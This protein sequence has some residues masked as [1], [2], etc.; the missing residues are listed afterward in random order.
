MHHS[1]NGGKLYQSLKAYQLESKKSIFE[2][3][4][5]EKEHHQLLTPSS[6]AKFWRTEAE[7]LRNQLDD[8]QENYRRLKGDELSGMRISD[9]HNLENELETRLKNIRIKKEKMLTDEIEELNRK[10]SLIGHE[11]IEL[12]KKVTLIHQENRELHKKVHG[13][14]D[15]RKE[16]GSCSGQTSGKES[17]V[18]LHLRQ[19][20]QQLNVSR[21]IPEC[22]IS[23]GLQLQ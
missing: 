20:E 4:N 3:Y 7:R 16:E 9:L 10:S 22:E 15:N 17:C 23:L 11:N 1:C 6:E 12:S 5:E 14:T 13:A 18:S 21:T 8:L 19:S 2:R